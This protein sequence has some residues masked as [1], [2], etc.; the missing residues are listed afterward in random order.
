VRGLVEANRAQDGRA[1]RRKGMDRKAIAELLGMTEDRV[2]LDRFLYTQKYPDEIKA[3]R[4]ISN[5]DPQLRQFRDRLYYPASEMMVLIDLTTEL[6]VKMR[7]PS[8]GGLPGLVANDTRFRKPVVP[9]TELLIQVKLLR[10][11]KGRIG[12]FSGVIADGR[13]DIVAENISKGTIITV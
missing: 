4:F 13:G 2:R 7:F 11:Y 10:N 3:W 8:L 6:L 5:G 1:Y 9:E 12:I